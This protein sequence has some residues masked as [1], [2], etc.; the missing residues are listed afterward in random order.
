MQSIGQKD[1]R[2]IEGTGQRLDLITSEI[3]E[4][5]MMT[6]CSLSVMYLT[7]FEGVRDLAA[8]ERR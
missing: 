8:T 7:S 6:G 1:I 3:Q 4:A 5:I 2:A